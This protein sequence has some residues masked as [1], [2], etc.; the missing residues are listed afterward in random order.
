MDPDPFEQEKVMLRNGGEAAFADAY[1]RVR[2]Q[3]EQIVSF[4]MNPTLRSRLDPVD[5]LQEAYLVASRRRD[6]FLVQTQVSFFVWIRQKVLQTMIDL[7]RFHTRERRNHLHEVTSQPDPYDGNSSVSIA[8]F[9][10]DDRTSPSMAAVRSEEMAQLESAL[11]SMNEL[12]REV[13]AMRHF[14]QM[15]NQ[16]VA[17]AL[18]LSVTAASNRYVRAMSKL[19]EIMKSFSIK[20]RSNS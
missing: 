14:E 19:G 12:D 15:S 2:S 10:I 4:R 18:Q 7:Q 17:E 16:Q 1:G 11:G 5:V 20:D 9:L 3:L 6:E 13:L 8:R